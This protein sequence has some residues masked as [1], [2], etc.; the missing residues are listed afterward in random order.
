M[1]STAL[2]RKLAG[3]YEIRK[4]LGEGGMGLVYRA[5]DSIIRREVAVKTIQDIPEPAE[6]P[7]PCRDARSEPLI[8]EVWIPDSR[9]RRTSP[10]QLPPLRRG[11][12]QVGRVAAPPTCRLFA[13]V[14]CSLTSGRPAPASFDVRSAGFPLTQFE[15]PQALLCLGVVRV[16]VQDGIELA[17]RIFIV[18]RSRMLFG[19]SE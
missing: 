14:G 3:R 5:Y 7:G 19:H 13:L 12:R 10:V 8:R 2:P 16:Q 18:A 6:G 9:Q 4:V 15:L 17:T 1:G 11:R